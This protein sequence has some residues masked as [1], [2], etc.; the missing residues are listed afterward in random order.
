MI[1]LLYCQVSSTMAVARDSQKGKFE[2][3]SKVQL[4]IMDYSFEDSPVTLPGINFTAGNIVAQMALIDDFRD[5]VIGV[6]LGTLVKDSR[7]AAVVENARTQPASP[8]AQRENKWLVRYNDTVNPA[9]NGNFEIPTPDL[10]LL[11]TG[12]EFMDLTDAAAIAL[13]D[14]IEA[15]GR[16]RLG[17]VIAVQNIEYVGRNI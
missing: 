13:V 7:Q 1:A 14:A 17:N 15:Y 6:T 2:M 8:F 9:G 3:A 5:A 12:G 16:S 11:T 4:S 10:A